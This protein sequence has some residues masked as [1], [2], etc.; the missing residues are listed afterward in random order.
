MPA[1]FS[2]CF[3]LLLPVLDLLFLISFRASH[4]TILR[5][6]IQEHQAGKALRPFQDKIDRLPGFT[7]KS[8]ENLARDFTVEDKVGPFIVA[9]ALS[10]KNPISKLERHIIAAQRTVA[11]MALAERLEQAPPAMFTAEIR[12]DNHPK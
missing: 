6:L 9:L 1:W 11:Y 3:L 4:P 10:S 2:A 7:S 5:S 12:G 8:S